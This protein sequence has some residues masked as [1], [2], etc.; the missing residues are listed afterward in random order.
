MDDSSAST[1]MGNRISWRKF[2]TIQRSQTLDSSSG[3]S[4]PSRKRKRVQSDDNP[5]LTKRRKHGS[6]SLPG[7]TKENLLAEA[8]TWTD[9]ETVNW[10]QLA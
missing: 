2:D 5:P 10:S 3:P 6:P 8:R 1:V 7:S 4:T 9:D